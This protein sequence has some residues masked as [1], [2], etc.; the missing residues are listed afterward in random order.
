MRLK[1]VR[2]REFRSVWDSQ[3]FE[4]GEITC[5]VGKNEAGK[6]AILKALYR[7]N[8][9]VSTDSQFSVTEDYP[10][11]YETDY[12]RDVKAGRRGPATVVEADF[13]LEPT[14]RSELEAEFGVG[15]V[16]KS[17]E[18]SLSRGYDNALHAKVHV[19]EK[20]AVVHI[21]NS[22][23][24][25][26]PL[27][28]EAV[29]AP[30]MQA[31]L[32]LLKS[33]AAEATAAVAAAR[34]AADSIADAD[35]KATALTTAEALAEPTNAKALREKIAPLSDPSGLGAY[36]WAQRLKAICPQFL[37]FDEYYQMEGQ[38][39]IEALKKRQAD[40]ALL[41]SDHPMLGLIALADLN[42][43]RLI[44]AENTQALKNSLEGAG[45]YLSRQIL[46]YWSQN[47]H[48]SL[49]FDLRPAKSGDPEHMRSGTNLWAEVY[50][51]AHLVTLRIGT[52]S[53]GFIWFFS[54]LAWFSQQQAQVKGRHRLILLL[55]E[56]GLFLHANAQSDLLRYFEVELKQEHQVI[57]TTH[58][59]F[60]IDP[61]HFD[62][63]RIV[64]DRSMEE[65]KALPIEEEGTKVDS[66]ILAGD[67]GTLFPLQGAL[68]YDIAQTLFV[69]PNNLVVEGVSDL[70]Y[71]PT[72][73]GLMAAAGKTTLDARWTITPVG[74]SDKVSTFIALLGS[75]R[76][77][78]VAVLIDMQKK[79]A[80]AIANLYKKKLLEKE[81]VFTF[82]DFTH[83]PE[84]DIEDM[85]D[86]QFYVDL[87]NAEY[88]KE[89]QAPLAL[90]AL[91]PHSRIVVRIEEHL[92]A[93]PLKAG[94][95]NHY[96]PARY[97][98]EN[99]ANLGPTL[100]QATLDRFDA[101]FK[102]LNALV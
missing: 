92:R 44:S 48:V 80:Q 101:A 2:V 3:P 46:K 50:D 64:R 14:E 26:S 62:R 29:G 78:N 35:E 47:K 67:P 56:P 102:A 13:V 70:L 52:R 53:R 42:L 15:I 63:V 68:G 58:S 9:L 24:L 85:F 19:N 38:V 30:S 18:V 81:K 25:P 69:G 89:L 31:L 84:A 96:R 7:L 100:G 72:I 11:A 5:L 55:D 82:A 17:P 27:V 75:Q 60:M 40:N 76:D 74:G 71:L 16:P 77:L 28:D 39:N 91:P 20:A 99:I 87:V 12:N 57:F 41:A 86:P 66:N 36:I 88:K 97:F 94:S 98:A 23:N 43:D 65:D 90:T 83:T 51:S 1:T 54:F 32:E 61:K 4:V 93:N 6:S 49:R 34:Q 95:F 8:P 22:A 59:P 45:N 21:V 10:R 37:Y 33:K 73:S 79:D